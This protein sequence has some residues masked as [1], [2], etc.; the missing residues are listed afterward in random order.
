MMNRFA[1]GLLFA[2]VLASALPASQVRAAASDSRDFSPQKQRELIR[3]LQSDT[4][5]ENK[6]I[7]C[8]QLAVCGTKDAVPA[9]AALLSDPRLASWARIA[10]EAIPG[11]AAD[12]ALR[13]AMGKLSGQLLIGAINSIAVRRDTKAVSGLVKKLKDADPDVA[14]AAAGALGHI[15]GIKAAKA[16]ERSLT[17]APADARPA[18]AEGC[19]LCAERLQIQGKVKDAVKLY[20]AVRQANVPKQRILEATRGAILARQSAGIP[21]LLEQLRSP[22]KEFFNIGLRTAR[23]LR[24]QEVTEALVAELDRCPPDRQALLLLAVA[25]RGDATALSAVLAA[26]RNGATKARIVAIGALERRGNGASVPVLLEAAAANDAA[27]AAAALA[28]LTRQPGNDVDAVL[29]DRLPQ[30]TGKMRQALIELAGRRRIDQALPA[31]LGFAKDSDAGVR[32]AAVQAIGTL[33]DD[34]QVNPILQLLQTNQEP[35]DRAELEAALVAIAGRSGARCVPPLL[36]LAKNG[37]TALRIIALHVLAS[38]GGPEALSTVKAAIDD[39]DEAVRD[40]AVR[41]LSTWPNNWPEESGVVEPLLTLAKNSR[42]ISYQVLGLRGYLQYV[43]SNPQIKDDDKVQKVNEVLPLIK[44]PEEQRLA[45]GVVGAIPTAAALKLLESFV[46]D[47]AVADDACAA[48]IK[49]ASEKAEGIPK[50]QRRQALQAVV[51]KSKDAPTQD[52]AKKA[53][54]GI[55]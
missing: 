14:T 12:A 6:A 28:A 20:N 49:F 42:K 13:R 48:I 34:Q 44:R 7:A 29:L 16:L 39:A 8:K 55:E 31:I 32:S 19:V 47:P 52:K 18:V 43:Q 50:E 38:A 26:A 2:T 33:G 3:A 9:L 21:L 5:P 1:L 27:V 41:T 40:E 30:A 35:K 46:A 37:D 54:K 51:E 53:L 45:I 36:P 15:G 4:A 22:D 17:T 25:D 23:E 10:L 11:L 24:G